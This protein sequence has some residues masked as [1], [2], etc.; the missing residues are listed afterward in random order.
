MNISARFIVRPVA[1][2]LLT[3]ALALAGALAFHRLPIAALP[4]LEFPVISVSAALPGASAETMA[5]TVA[6]PLER[7]LGTIAGVNEITSRSSL[8]STSITLQF[9]LARNIDGAARDVQAAIQA[10]R[11]LLPSGLP[12]NP[13]YRKVNPANAPIMIVALTSST[14]SRG[15]MYDAASTVLAQRLA[16]LE[17]VGQVTI[18]GGALPAVRIALDPNK[19]AAQ[20]ISLEQVRLALN[21]GDAH[22]PQG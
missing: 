6:T 5:A 4:E 10:A 14:L 11:S 8:G 7:A 2:T 19:L 22:R 20:G 18:G 15:Q 3:L 21:A 1:T 13:S 17:G 12:S 16:Q 9:D